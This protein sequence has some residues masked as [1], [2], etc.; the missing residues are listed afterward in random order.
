ME[1]SAPNSIPA[2]ETKSHPLH[3]LYDDAD[4]EENFSMAFHEAFGTDLVINWRGGNQFRSMLDRA[5]SEQQ[6]LIVF[7]TNTAKP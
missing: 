7:R 4:L 5:R 1:S 3:R 6:T 2:H